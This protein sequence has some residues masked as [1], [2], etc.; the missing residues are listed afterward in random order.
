MAFS[1]AGCGIGQAIDN[2]TPSELELATRRRDVASQ[3]IE[4]ALTCDD[5]LTIAVPVDLLPASV[6]RESKAFQVAVKWLE[7]QERRINEE[8]PAILRAAFDI[9][10]AHAKLPMEAGLSLQET[11]EMILELYRDPAHRW[12]PARVTGGK[13]DGD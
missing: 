13:T 8:C 4:N 3:V 11:A 9:R 7:D 2:T 5:R 12:F 6:P 1:I 10:A